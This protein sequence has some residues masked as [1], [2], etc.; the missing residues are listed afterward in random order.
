LVRLFL[1]NNLEANMARR[2][3]SLLVISSALMVSAAGFASANPVSKT[4]V[5]AA[6]AKPALVQAAALTATKLGDLTPFR[7]IAS[8]TLDIVKKGDLGAAATRAKDLETMWDDH[9]HAMRALDKAEWT[10]IDKALD[11]TFKQL[12][13]DKPDATGCDAVLTSLIKIMDATV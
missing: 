3:F 5:V 11:A 4:P 9:A 8:D 6:P 1:S 12:R 13:A 7:A 10:A 2:L